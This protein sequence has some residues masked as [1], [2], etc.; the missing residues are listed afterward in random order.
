MCI[1]CLGHFWLCPC[2]FPLPP[3]PS[4][5]GKTGSA[6]FFNLLRGNISNNKKGIAFLLVWDKGSY[7]ERFLALL[8]CTCVLQPK[9]IH[10]YLT[11]SLFS[12]HLPIVTFVVLRLQWAHQTLSSFGFPNFPYSSCMCSPLSMW[13]MSNNITAFVLG[14]KSEYEEEHTIFGL[15]SLANLAQNDFLQFHPCTCEW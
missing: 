14:L 3:T 13:S 2:P 11:S 9:L 12:S 8:L 6:L 15:L 4:L 10:L 5:L 7:T 1:Y